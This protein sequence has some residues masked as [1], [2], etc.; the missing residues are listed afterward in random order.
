MHCT[1]P[2]NKNPYIISFMLSIP[3]IIIIHQTKLISLMIFLRLTECALLTVEILKNITITIYNRRVESGNFNYCMRRTIRDRTFGFHC[4]EGRSRCTKNIDIH[5]L[6]CFRDNSIFLYRNIM[7]IFCTIR[8]HY[9]K[10]GQKQFFF[11]VTTS[12]GSLEN[13]KLLF[14]LTSKYS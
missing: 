1:M 2:V 6:V 7:F 4:L 13:R 14:I 11:Y 9:C 5:V 12:L 8:L 10:S 3:T